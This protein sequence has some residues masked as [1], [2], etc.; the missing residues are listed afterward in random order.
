MSKYNIRYSFASYSSSLEEDFWNQ[1]GTN[2][3]FNA[4]TE[5]VFY[6]TY[7]LTGDTEVE[8]WD[9]EKKRRVRKKLKDLTYNDLVLCWN[10][11]K[12]C[13]DYAKPIYITKNNASRYAK[14]SFSDGSFIKAC[15]PDDERR[16]RLFSCDTNRFEYI[17]K[18]LPI[19]TTTFNSKGEKVKVTKIEFV[20]ERVEYYNVYT[21]YHFNMF[22]N[23]ILT[24]GRLNNLYEIRDMKYVKDN[25]P[26]RKREEFAE[27]D[28]ETFYGLRLAE[29]QDATNVGQHLGYTSVREYVQHLLDTRISKD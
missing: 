16:H 2:P 19:G 7:C 15:G 4:D 9:D 13:F 24:S 21:T 22:A 14:V 8:V 12:G 10:F 26:L 23:G 27:F 18:N 11:D 29:Q 3:T 6:Y 1:T 28:D 5:I 20:D 17:G 25:R